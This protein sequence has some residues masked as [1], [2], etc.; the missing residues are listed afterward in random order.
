[1]VFSV[2]S[3]DGYS[4]R[5]AV[6]VANVVRSSAELDDAQAVS[7]GWGVR[8]TQGRGVDIVVDPIGV[9]PPTTRFVCWPSMARK[10][11]A[12]RPY[13]SCAGFL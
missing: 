13:G 1:M 12:A 9:R 3:L 5:V 7:L 11:F 8:Q 2:R 6:P 4:E 10:T